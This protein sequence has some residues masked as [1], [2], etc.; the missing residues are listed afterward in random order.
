MM[1]AIPMT[2]PIAIPAI[3]P[4]ESFEDEEVASDELSGASPAPLV[5][6]DEA[7]DAEPVVLDAEPVALDTVLVAFTVVLVPPAEVGVDWTAVGSPPIWDTVLA[8]LLAGT[9]TSELAQT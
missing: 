7:L 6:V 9:L 8:N 1:R 3:A 5:P 4:V 2:A